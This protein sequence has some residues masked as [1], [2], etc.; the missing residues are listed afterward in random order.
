MIEPPQPPEPPPI[1][2]IN[3]DKEPLEKGELIWCF[4][5]AIFIISLVFC[6]HL[7]GSLQAA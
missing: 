1:R 4:L 2:V 5:A 3:E 7:R 6:V